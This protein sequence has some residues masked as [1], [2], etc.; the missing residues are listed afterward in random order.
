MRIMLL[1]VGAVGEAYAVLAQKGDPNGEWLEQL[2]LADFNLNRAREV[3]AKLG[4]P[5]RFPAERVDVTQ[6]EQIVA[7]ARK[8]NVNLIM[9][10]CA[11]VFNVPIFEGTYEA[12]CNYM[13][14][15]MTLSEM[16]VEDPYNKVGVMLGDYQFARHQAWK[17]KGLL[18]LVAMGVDP[19]MS[20]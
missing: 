17:E 13:D 15:A 4:D 11:Q 19:G 9:N 8:Y 14:M 7:L 1:G 2:V 18:A 6:K 5:V 16:N 20:Q 12:G 3:Q 10:A